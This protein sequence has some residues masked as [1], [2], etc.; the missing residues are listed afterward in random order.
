MLAKLPGH[1]EKH[2]C[3]TAWGH[4]CV[5]Y[6]SPLSEWHTHLGRYATCCFPTLRQ[7]S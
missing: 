1:W 6:R 7:D 2:L 3:F 4:S 5:K